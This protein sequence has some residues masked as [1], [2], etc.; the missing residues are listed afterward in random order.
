MKFRIRAFTCNKT[1]LVI[2]EKV[3][4]GYVTP[5]TRSSFLHTFVNTHG[6][7]SKMSDIVQQTAQV[8]LL[9]GCITW[10]TFRGAVGTLLSLLNP[11]MWIGES[12][13][14]ATFYIGRVVHTRTKPLKRAFSYPIRFAVI[15]LDSPPP[16]FIRSGQAGDHLSADKVRERTGHKGPVRLFT[17]PWAFGYM[18]NPISVYYSYDLGTDTGMGDPAGKF[19]KVQLKTCIAE[20]TN[21]PWG[22]RVLFNFLPDG[23]RVPKSLHVSPFLDMQ[24]EWELMAVDPEKEFELSVA[25]VEHPTFGDY[26]YAKLAAKRD[27][28]APHARNERGGIRCLLQ[29]TCAPHRIAFWI[30]AEA[31]SL[32][33]K[34]LS[35]YPPPGLELVA[36]AA[37]QGGE[38][39][40]IE[41]GKYV[42]INCPLRATW[43]AARTWPW[44]T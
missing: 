14:G 42:G 10:H 25:V 37:C 34:R 27:Q 28:S 8:F 29:H 43:H 38:V 36:K 11:N 32:I 39:H 9:L 2:I 20:V 26:F 13:T 17:L 16:W 23:S 15:D 22:E 21:T 24:G 31:L 5:R 33:S 18:Q 41:S 19:K 40:E 6:H 1:G 12:C 30:Y 3:L 35:I 44:K 4:L 7:K